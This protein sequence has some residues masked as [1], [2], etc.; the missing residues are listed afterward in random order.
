MLARR[1]ALV[2]QERGFTLV[3]LLVATVLGLIVI[4]GA[5]TVFTVSMNNQPRINS[6][7][8]AIQQAR[9]V[10]ERMTREL[11]QGS[12]VP[13]A[14]ANQLAIV[15]YVDSATCGGAHA[16]TAR[17]CRVTYTCTS[18]ACTRTEANPDGS[19]T[20]S[21]VQVVSGLSSSNVFTYSPSSSAPTYVGVTLSFPAISGHHAITLS[22]GAATR[23]P[24][25]P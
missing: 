12:S 21:A 23:N 15:T 19:S 3:E 24:T 7:S 17:Q 11:R 8:A 13:T 25:S 9:V 16:T 10:M 2:A 5:V 6:Q 1:R 14:T 22:D 4:G 20:G 18:G